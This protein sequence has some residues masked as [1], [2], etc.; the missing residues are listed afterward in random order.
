MFLIRKNFNGSCELIQ[1][2]SILLLPT[3]QS[4]G[5]ARQL[6]LFKI[7][8]K[9]LSARR[10]AGNRP[11]ITSLFTSNLL[12]G[13]ARLDFKKNLAGGGPEREDAGIEFEEGCNNG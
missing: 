5:Y 8:E 7:A 13:L 2:L 1:A 3:I 6:Y 9:D 12:T 10:P 11:I 4:K